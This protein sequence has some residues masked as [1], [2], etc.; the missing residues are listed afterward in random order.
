MSGADSVA[1]I[2]SDLETIR[3]A[4]GIE[5]PFGRVD[6]WLNLAL[7]P[8]GAALAGWAMAAPAAR[9]VPYGALPAILVSCALVWL[10][11]RY[12]RA[13]G[14][15]AAR[16][17][18]YTFHIALMVALPLVV[19]A[20]L[21]F[22]RRLGVPPVTRGASAVFFTGVMSVVLGAA[23][24]GKRSFIVSGLVLV[25]WAP[26]IPYSSDREVAAGAGIVMALAGLGGAAVQ[27]Y[28]LR[29]ATRGF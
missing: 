23:D 5:L 22:E 21:A 10:R 6:V 14:R 1:R 26:L 4:A 11:Y 15:S 24:R 12:R 9:L 29:R 16:R 18:E 7:V 28:Q 2:R 19:L 20:Y 17:R 13:T 3:R 8:A 25:L 27:D